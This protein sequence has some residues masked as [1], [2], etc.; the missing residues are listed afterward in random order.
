MLGK[1]I[2]RIKARKAR[3]LF[4]KEVKDFWYCGKIYNYRY[5]LY[6]AG[7]PHRMEDIELPC[8]RFLINPYINAGGKA[9]QVGDI[10][11]CVKKD[12]W[13]G[14]YQVVRKYRYLGTTS[15]DF[16]PWDDG[17]AIDLKF[18]HCEEKGGDA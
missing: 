7:K 5:E 3:R 8:E 12:G 15:D 1:I 13:I 2:R 6:M 11:P 18:H 16:A 4:P 10:I 17:K 14:Y 9:P